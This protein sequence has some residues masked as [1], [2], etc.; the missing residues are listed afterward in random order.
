VNVQETFDCPLGCV[1]PSHSTTEYSL[2]DS[3]DPSIRVTY[4]P[5]IHKS[6]QTG[7]FAFFADFNKTKSQS[8][9]QPITVHNSKPVAVSGV[10][11]LDQ[12]PVSE[13][14]RINVSLVSP[15]LIVPGSEEARLGSIKRIAQSVK[16]Q[17]GVSAQWHGEQGDD[18]P[19]LGKDGRV[20]WVCELAA[21]EKL[22]LSLEYEVSAPA[23]VTLLGI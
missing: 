19:A 11:I 2:W 22:T 13:D 20:K 23:G 16:V 21:Q 8:H 17:K 3:I 1:H 6:S 12:V 14:E 5:A 10:H 4:H 18:D 15:A 7:G 9:I